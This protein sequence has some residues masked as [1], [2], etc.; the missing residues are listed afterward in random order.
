MPSAPPAW[1]GAANGLYES[2]FGPDGGDGPAAAGDAPRPEAMDAEVA[3]DVGPEPEPAAE[4]S[5]LQATMA[6]LAALDFPAGPPPGPAPVPPSLV[7]ANGGP[8]GD[9]ESTDEDL[10]D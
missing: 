10:Q 6:A 5:P 4:V 2:S 8:A 1:A 9:P 3:E 7:P